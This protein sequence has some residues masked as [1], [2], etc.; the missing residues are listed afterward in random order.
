MSGKEPEI[1]VDRAG[2]VA[3]IRLNRPH[4]RNALNGPLL[5]QLQAALRSS[6]S[7]P[8]VGS[9]LLTGQGTAFCA[10]ADLKETASAMAG[11]DFWSQHERATQSMIMHGLL[12][13]SPKPVIAAVNG[14]ALAGGCAVAM[15]CDLVIASD[16]ARFGYPEVNRGLVAAMAMVTLSRIVPRRQALELLLTGRTLDAHEALALGMVNQVTPHAGLMDAALGLAADIAAKSPGALR[17]TKELYNQVLELDAARA[18]EHARDVNQ[19]VKFVP[20]AR[21]GAAAFGSV[22][23]G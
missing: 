12:T 16:Q 2:R 5:E 4:A 18:M 13:G 21:S 3:V 15:S 14:P 8:Q 6:A 20:D 9:V 17:V 22:S 10:G 23:T 7:D 1:L 19:M 11:D